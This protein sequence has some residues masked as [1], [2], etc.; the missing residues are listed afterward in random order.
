MP[1]RSDTLTDLLN[2]VRAAQDAIIP[3]ERAARQALMGLRSSGKGLTAQGVLSDVVNKL[4]D[5]S[6]GLTTAVKD[7]ERQVQ[8]AREDEGAASGKVT[9]YIDEMNKRR[10]AAPNPLLKPAA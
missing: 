7:L 1:S 2:N 5:E 10:G 4:E 9:K 8:A 3:V 6:R